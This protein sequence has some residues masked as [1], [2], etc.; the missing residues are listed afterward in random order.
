[1]TTTASSNATAL[2]TEARKAHPSTRWLIYARVAS[3]FGDGFAKVVQQRVEQIETNC[4]RRT[5]RAKRK[6]G[7]HAGS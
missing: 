2:I 3:D 7:A 6:G 4:S 1:M 5:P